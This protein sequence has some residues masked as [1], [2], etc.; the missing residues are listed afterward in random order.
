MKEVTSTTYEKPKT[1]HEKF[2]EKRMKKPMKEK[3]VKKIEKLNLE[4]IFEG[5]ENAT[6]PAVVVAD[7]V[8]EIIDVINEKPTKST[9]S[10][11]RIRT[12]KDIQDLLDL[13]RKP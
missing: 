7:K 4:L 5:E 12:H 2:M 3:K 10:K 11:R 1:M 6:Y 8:N 9:R 13:I